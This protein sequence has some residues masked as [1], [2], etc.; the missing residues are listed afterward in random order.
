MKKIIYLAL[1]AVFFL[2]ISAPSFAKLT[3]VPGVS[4][5]EEYNDNIFL[6]VSSKEDDFITTVSPGVELE[7]SHGKSLDMRLD[8]GLNFRFYSDHSNLNDTSIR[9]TQ[10]VEFQ[11]QARPFNRVF[12]DISDVYDRVPVDV[13]ERFAIDNAYSNMTDRNTFSVSP[14]MIL[15]LT[16]TISTTI[17]YSYSN[18]WHRAEEPVDSYSHSAFMTIDKRFS[19][20]IN[21]ALKYRYLAYRPE[22]SG[23]GT[24]V[25]EYDRHEGSVG[26]VYQATEGF[27]INGEVG[28]SQTD[29]QGT[30]NTKTTFWNIGTDYNFGSSNIGAT[31]NYSLNDSPISGSFKSS[32]IDLRLETGRVLR[33]IVNPY[34]SSDKYININRK[35]KITGVAFNISKP[36]SGKVNASLDAE[37]ERQELLPEDEKVRRYSL[38]SSLDYRLSEGITAGIGYRYN[39]RDSDTGADEFQNNIVR[40]QAKLTF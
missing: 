8:Y 27:R 14:Y 6:D 1:L 38:G 9:E 12:I 13:R 36:L 15:P 11:S 22:L 3:V 24:S 23:D 32:R 29:F 7:Y 37:L 17:G 33:L 25:N 26:I 40:L 39:E 31:Y 30:D 19:S 28:R 35:D 5:K 34:Y 16:S 20:K 4:V 10:N 18:I 2:S 21:A